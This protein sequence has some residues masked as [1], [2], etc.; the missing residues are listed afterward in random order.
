MKKAELIA[1]IQAQKPRLTKAEIQTVIDGLSAAARETIAEGDTFA[2]PGVVRLDVID[3]A[4][5]TGRN[6]H[7][8]EAIEI[9]AKRAIKARAAGELIT[10][11]N[12]RG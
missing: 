10:V 8:G 9:A 1:A 11:A 3:R 12:A 5:R 6:P 4:A 2:I 7:T